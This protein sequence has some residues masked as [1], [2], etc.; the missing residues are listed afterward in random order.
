MAAAACETSATLRRCDRSRQEGT[1]KMQSLQQHRAKEAAQRSVLE[2]DLVNI[3]YEY[4][5]V[6]EV[7][8]QYNLATKPTVSK[9]CDEKQTRRVL[10]NQHCTKRIHAYFLCVDETDQLLPQNVPRH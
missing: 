6:S 10:V 5:V 7:A 2:T 9:C 8:A 4:D 3:V 1:R